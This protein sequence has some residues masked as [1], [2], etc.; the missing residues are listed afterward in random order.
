M[1]AVNAS[2][3]VTSVEQ[4]ADATYRLRFHAPELAAT[5]RP[6]Q[7]LNVLTSDMYD[8]LLRRPYSISM[9]RGKECE[10]LFSVVGKGTALLAEMREGEQLGVLGPLGN[11]FGYDKPFDTAII[12]AGGIG[13]A[14]FPYL[15][16]Y[17][18]QRGKPVHT[19]LGARNAARVVREGL[20][21]LHIA[22][23]DG[24]EAYHGTS[25]ACLDAF[26]DATPVSNARIFACGPNAMLAAAQELA[27]RRGIPCELSL[28]SEMACGVGICQGCPIER[29]EGE[30]K[31]ALVCT[32]GPCFDSADIIFHG[33]HHA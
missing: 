24:S 15:T 12:V 23:D 19:F 16:S 33:Q 27:G 11:T 4:V 14:P 31:Y 30:R 1:T 25:V 2:F 13:V 5:L 8:P 18:R 6:G 9:V 20:D 28:E 32:D 7:F 3:P 26:L 21:G 22:T 29:V 10:I 17:L